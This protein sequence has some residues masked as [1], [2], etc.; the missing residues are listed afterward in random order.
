MKIVVCIKPIKTELVCPNENR[1][2]KFL[3]NPY[4]LKAFLDCVAVKKKQNAEL[5]CLCM[6]P[7]DSEPMLVKALA[8][9]ADQ[10][11]LLNDSAFAGSDT[12]A[13]SYILAKAIEKIGDVTVV[14]CG[15]KSVDGETGQVVYGIAERLNYTCIS[16]V[17]KIEEL[18][19][20][21]I[22]VESKKDDELKEIRTSCPVV[23][24]YQELQ[25][26]Q[27]IVNLLALK[28]AK[29]IGITIWKADDIQADASKIGLSGS[30]T[31]VLNVKQD[32][33]KKEQNILEG[34]IEE[35]VRAVLDVVTGKRN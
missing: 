27:P 35:K 24:V 9:G 31:K 10:A 3:I 13:T 18:D 23:A 20:T 21:G 25:V 5:V 1:A 14:A 26:K 32:I 16:G 29:R 7:M 34:S 33:I 28:K 17:Q 15:E 19:E 22:L 11:I 6:G 8:M 30:R 12:V 2:E 4:D